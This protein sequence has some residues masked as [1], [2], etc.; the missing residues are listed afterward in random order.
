MV[1][2]PILTDGITQLIKEREQSIAHMESKTFM[3][4]MT[5]LKMLATIEREHE[6]ERE[7][8]KPDP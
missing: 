3:N 7:K 5:R 8:F 4:E 1:T 2:D 6:F